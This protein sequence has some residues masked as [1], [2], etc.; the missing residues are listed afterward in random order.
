MYK[1]F[2]VLG[3]GKALL[4]MPDIDA[5][6]IININIHSIAIKHYGGNDNCCT[7]K[8]TAQHADTTQETIRTEKCYSNTDDISKS[9]NTEKP[10]VNNKLSN[11]IDYFLLGSNCD[12]AKKKSAEI[13]QQLQRD[14]EDVF[15]GI[16][17]FDCTFSLQLKLDSKPYQAPPR[18]VA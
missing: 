11:T 18:C 4:G 10:I 7:N 14:F 3:I 2:V 17:C 16:G 6:N 1:F 12:S 8:A 13:T 9:D 5:L 15:Y